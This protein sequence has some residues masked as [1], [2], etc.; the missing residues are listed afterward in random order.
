MPDMIT[1][2]F[3]CKRLCSLIFGTVRKSPQYICIL[4]VDDNIFLIDVSEVQLFLS[5]SMIARQAADSI[6]GK[7]KKKRRSH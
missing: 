4:T 3:I 1:F 5:K 6:F 7:K 2:F